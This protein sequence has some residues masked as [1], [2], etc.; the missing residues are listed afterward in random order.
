MNKKLYN[1]NDEE[2][3]HVIKLLRELPKEKA[4]DNF[5]YNLF[6][7]IENKNFGLNTKEPKFTLPLKFLIPATGVMLSAVFL[8]FVVVF[9]LNP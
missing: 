6:T 7:K 4:P 1:S 5:E 3:Q 2:H 8:F 9:K